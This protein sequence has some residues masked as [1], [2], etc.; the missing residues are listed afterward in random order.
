MTREQVALV[1]FSVALELSQ[2]GGMRCE[3]IG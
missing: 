2:Q 1:V 3:I